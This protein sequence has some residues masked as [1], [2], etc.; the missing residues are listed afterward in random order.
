MADLAAVWEHP[1]RPV[2]EVMRRHLG[3]LRGRRV[4]L[5]GN[6]GSPFELHLLAGGPQLLLLTDLTA[7]GV[8]AVAA[9]VELSGHEDRVCFAAMDA[10]RLPLADASVDVVYGNAIIHHVPVADRA[11]CL[12]ELARVLAPG[13]R[14][15]FMDDAH[16]PAWQAAKRTWLRPLMRY[17]HR[18]QP[19]SPEDV[20]HTEEG[21]F[22]EEELTAAI[23]SAGGEPRFERFGLVFHLWRRAATTLL[24]PALRRPVA[25]SRCAGRVLTALDRA[26][27]RRLAVVRRNQM[28]LVWGWRQPPAG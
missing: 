20:R 26:L 23:R 12:A 17:S 4:L 21:G 28:R 25:N 7:A 15:V 14:A 27:A 2:Y 13:G 6:G 9:R 16:V 10:M 11:R 5:I 22:R 18:V 3:D 1:A 8:R 24:P 19:R